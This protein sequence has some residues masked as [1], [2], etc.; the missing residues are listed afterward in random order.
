MKPIALFLILVLTPFTTMIN[1]NDFSINL[2]IKRLKDKGL[3]EVILQIKYAY[4]QDVAI[5]SCEELNKNNCGNCKKVVIEYMPKK[6]KN[7]NRNEKDKG[8][9]FSKP[10]GINNIMKPSRKVV[11]EQIIS[12]MKDKI[13]NILEKK[14]SPKNSELFANNIVVKFAI[15][16]F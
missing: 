15:S 1:I 10:K 13:K 9:L 5:I 2:F 12:E 6:K 8:S 3:F 14:L 11:I 4:G 16:K 7:E